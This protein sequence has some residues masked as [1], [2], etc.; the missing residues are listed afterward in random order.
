MQRRERDAGGSRKRRHSDGEEP[1]FQ[2]A[3]SMG[4]RAGVVEEGAYGG[5]GEAWVLRSLGQERAATAASQRSVA[6]RIPRVM[7]LSVSQGRGEDGW[8]FRRMVSNI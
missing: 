1:Y 7:S 5:G 6:R 4:E 2:T 8:S 3:G